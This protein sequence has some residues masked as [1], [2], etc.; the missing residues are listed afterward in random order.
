MASAANTEINDERRWN[1]LQRKAQEVRVGRAFELLRSEGIEPILIKGFAAGRN[2]PDSIV[3][4]SIDTDL[5]VAEAD[6][7]RAAAIAVSS[8]ADGLAIDLHRALRHLDTLPWNDLF[9]NSKLVEID[10][11]TVRVLRPEDHL[12]V[13]CVHWLNDGA[14]NKDR[15]WDIYYAVEN[16]APDFDWHR[17]LDPVSSRRRRWLVCTI[18]LASHFLGLD[19]SDP[20]IKAEARDLPDWLIETVEREWA[21]ETKHVP[22][23]A[24]IKD[25]KVLI[26]QFIKR[27]RPNP[28]RATIEMEGSLDARTRIFYQIANFFMRIAPSFRRVSETIRFEKISGRKDAKAPK[29]KEEGN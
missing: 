28:I 5:A 25:R 19:L 2:Y 20:P 22:M 16:R 13:L 10:G 7:E 29:R 3:R 1:M 9:E 23:E 18:G 14:S 12:R 26:K 8:A 24:A 21:S 11:G 17:F 15:L 6:Y 27:F 4:L